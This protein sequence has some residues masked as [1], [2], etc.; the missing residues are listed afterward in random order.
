MPHAKAALSCERAAALTLRLG[1]EL[2]AALL[3]DADLLALT[4][5]DD[6]LAALLDVHLRHSSHAALQRLG[7]ERD[8]LHVAMVTQLAGNRPK[9][10]TEISISIGHQR[11]TRL[12]SIRQGD[13][14]ALPKR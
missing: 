7:S 4:G 11:A 1:L 5:Q 9:A 6:D 12:R 13:V 10:G 8:D 2:G 14:N 3:A